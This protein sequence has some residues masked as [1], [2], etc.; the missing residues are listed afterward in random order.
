MEDIIKG[1]EAARQADIAIVFVQADS[2]EE[3]GKVEN[4]KGDRPDLKSWHGGDFLVESVAKVNKNTIVI[5]NAPATVNVPWLDQV[6]GVIFAG[7]PGAE[8]G[9]GI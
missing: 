4:T 5:I 6:K 7:F 3:Y 9:N 2:G 8:S 1:T